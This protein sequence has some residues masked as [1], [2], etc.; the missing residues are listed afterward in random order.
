M[1]MQYNFSELIADN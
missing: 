1:T